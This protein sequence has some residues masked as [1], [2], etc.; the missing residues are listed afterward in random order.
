MIE[1]ILKRLE[2]AA[3]KEKALILQRFFK[4]GVGQY[5]EGDLFFGIQVPTLRSLVKEF[6]ALPMEE[7]PRLLSS[8]YH[9]AR[10]LAIL[11]L[12]KKYSKASPI[13]QQKIYNFYLDNTAYINNWDLV[14]VSA[15]HIVGH[16]LFTKDRSILYSLASTGNLWQ[17]RIAIIATA[18]FIKKA[19]FNDTLKISEILLKDR[20]D[21][22]HKAVG[23]MLREVGK[24]DIEIEKSFLAKYYNVMPRVML[25]YAI[26]K[27]PEQE[28]KQYLKGE[29]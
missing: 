10:F 4:T 2:A 26:E 28:R 27:F 24:K 9:E 20:E 11:I 29:K 16:Y 18:Y 14:D 22:I 7:T 5:G 13:E 1:E 19:D 25:R 21:L 3:N 12:V 6:Q 8:P 15:H 23:W 17:R